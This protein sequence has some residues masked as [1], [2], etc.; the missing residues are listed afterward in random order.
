MNRLRKAMSRLASRMSDKAVAG[1]TFTFHRPGID[2]IPVDGWRAGQLSD[3][4]GGDVPLNSQDHDLCFMASE[5]AKLPSLPQQYDRFTDDAGAQYEVV[6]VD[7]DLCWRKL[8]TFGE[9][10]RV[11]TQLVR[12][13]ED[14]GDG[15]E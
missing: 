13:G 6:P 2:P 12:E 4:G 9:G 10:Y 3:A 11:H 14:D 1:E 15:A 5:L 8:D 7:R